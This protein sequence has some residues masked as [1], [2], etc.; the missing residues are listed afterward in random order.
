MR[1]LYLGLAFSVLPKG[2][3]MLTTT[4]LLPVIITTIAVGVALAGFMFTVMLVFFRMLNQRVSESEERVT[5]LITETVARLTRLI[6]ETEARI[7]V[8]IDANGQRIDN[9]E[10]RMQRVEQETAEIKGALT[11]IQNALPIR[12]G[13]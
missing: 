8:R 2:K 11:V 13:D 9:L 1:P 7:T 3:S 12:I 4:D 6:S 10:S 5:R